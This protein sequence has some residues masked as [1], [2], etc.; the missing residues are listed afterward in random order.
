M[1]PDNQR[2][3]IPLA[4]GDA[5]WGF[6]WYGSSCGP[7][8][9]AIEIQTRDGEPI[10]APLRGPQPS[11][12]DRHGSFLVDGVAGGSEEPVQAARPGFTDLQLSAS[13]ARGT[14][15]FQLAPIRMTLR[16]V[17]TTPVPLD[18]CPSYGGDYFARARS[19]GFGTGLPSGYLPCTQQ[20][21]SV[22]PGHP[23]H[24]TIPAA[25]FDEDATRRSVVHVRAGIAGVPVVQ[26]SVTV[27]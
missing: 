20:M 26:L 4:A 25:D 13:M 27:H 14:T 24:F 6:A 21:P 3:D 15:Q 9:A 19:G 11:C 18:P 7:R 5:A 12:T 16:T 23:V 8:A 10:R 22:R 2:S 1:R 17:G